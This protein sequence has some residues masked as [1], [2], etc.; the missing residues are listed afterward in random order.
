[1][2]VRAGA[3]DW[4]RYLD[5]AFHD[6]APQVV[7][8][9]GVSRLLI[10]GELWPRHDRGSATS[11]DG[12]T[13]D[14]H[15]PKNG[16]WDPRVRLQHMDLEG[17]DVAVL[18]GGSI[19][20]GIGA[21]KDPPFAAAMARAYNRWLADFCA[22]DTAR[23]KGVASIPPQSPRDA[24]AELERVAA[25]GF[26]TV[27]LPPNVNGVNLNDERFLPVYAA[28]EQTGL[29]VSVHGGP[30]IPCLE[31]TAAER[32]TNFHMV[33][34]IAHPFEMMMAV[35]SV[36]AGGIL[37]R[38]P[39]LRF[40]FLEAGV[41]W[42]PYWFERLDGHYRTL[43]KQ[44]P[45]QAAPSEYVKSGQCWFSCECGEETLPWALEAL[46]E[47]RVVYASDYWHYDAKFP[48]SVKAVASMSTITEEQ[49]ARVL[50][51]NAAKLYDITPALTA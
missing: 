20:L 18:F 51:L 21:F 23:L 19:C 33:H 6:R 37:D 10:E 5:P 40:A 3:V 36:I 13:L 7:T 38:H 45:A 35:A 17:I 16:M 44:G 27:G 43:G 47:D 11:R 46:G 29:A 42:A 34:A 9:D 41:G 49:K 48:N 30:R 8:R 39:R 32:F 25:Q 22:A 31:V 24:V 15:E 50:G 28:A 4:K 1:M 14:K 26:V 2:E 12:D